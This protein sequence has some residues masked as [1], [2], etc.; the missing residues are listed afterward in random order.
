MR[1]DGRESKPERLSTLEEKTMI[2]ESFPC[3]CNGYMEQNEG[4]LRQVVL[5]DKACNW[6]TPKV[7]RTLSFVR[8]IAGESK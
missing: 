6:D 5:V 1:K 8:Y 2:I 4:R 3:G 7:G